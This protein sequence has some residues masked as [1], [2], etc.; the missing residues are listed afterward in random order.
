MKKFFSFSTLSA[1]STLS[2]LS[3]FTL[4]S[5]SAA[6]RPVSQSAVTAV[7][8]PRMT[9][10]EMASYDGARLAFELKAS[11]ADLVTRDN[12]ALVKMPRLKIYKKDSPGSLLVQAG[13]DR[14]EIRLDTKD[15]VLED[16]V[17]YDV[18]PKNYRLTTAK[19]LYWAQ[20]GETEVPVGTG[21]VLKTPDG[22]AEGSGMIA[23]EDLTK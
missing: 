6:K 10:F 22:L 23:R 20:R 5:C 1:L 12:R 7:E 15:V 21:Y 11:I 4:V 19:L 13:G 14:G 17:K 16:N 2:T 3:A 18:I 9:D 8:H